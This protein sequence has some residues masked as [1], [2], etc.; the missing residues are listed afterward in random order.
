M[1]DEK[2]VP[3]TEPTTPT[4]PPT[5]PK[6]KAFKCGKCVTIIDVTKQNLVSDMGDFPGRTLPPGQEYASSASEP[7]PGELA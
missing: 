5:R 1:A 7:G 4:T 6:P 2:S 3:S